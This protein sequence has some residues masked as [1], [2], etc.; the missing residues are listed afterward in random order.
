MVGSRGNIKEWSGHMVTHTTL[1]AIAQQFLTISKVILHTP[2]LVPL[3]G[4]T[5]SSSIQTAQFGKVMD[6]WK[7]TN[8][9]CLA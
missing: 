9:K 7:Q 3:C 5:M 2:R 1:I 6:L 4:P 8:V